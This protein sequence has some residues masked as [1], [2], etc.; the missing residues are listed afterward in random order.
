MSRYPDELDT[1]QDLPR[2][3]D[4]VT[5]VGA[6]AI[7]AVREAIFAIEAVLGVDPQG[8]QTTL[9]DRIAVSLNAN[10]TLRADAIAASGLVA[11]PIDD[12]D[13]A[14]NAGIQESKL[15]LNVGT[16]ALQ[17]Q[18]TSNDVDI[19]NLQNLLT[20]LDA[21][22]TAHTI[23]DFGRHDGYDIDLTPDLAGT[24]INTVAGA[25][26]HA[27]TEFG[28]HKAS[29]DII[30]HNAS[31]IAYAPSDESALTVDNVQDAIDAIDSGFLQNIGR[32]IDTAHSN[33]VSNDGYVVLGGQ[34]VVN[35]ASLRATR[36]VPTGGIEIAKLGLVNA[37]TI[38]SRGFSA[39]SISS[40]AQ[41]FDIKIY[42]GGAVETVSVTGLNLAAYPLAG[43]VSLRGV[44]TAINTALTATQA[45][46]T[47]FEDGNE[48]VLQH[49]IADADCYLSVEA[50]GSNS[51]I[52]ALGFASVVGVQV[53]RVPSFV[54]NVDTITRTE[55]EEV[56]V[57][58]LTLAL[59]STTL[60]LGVDVGSGG[61]NLQ[62]GQLI[63]LRDHTAAGDGTYKIQSVAASPGTTI[64]VN[65]AVPA[66]S[67]SYVIYGDTF[68]FESGRRT[69]DACVDSA[70][71]PVL[72]TRARVTVSQIGGMV[73]SEVSE[74]FPAV[75]GV[76]SVTKSSAT[77]SVKCTVGGVDGLTAT[78]EQGFIGYIKLWHPNNVDFLIYY[79]RDSSPSAPVTDTIVFSERSGRDDL[80]LVGSVFANGGVVEYPTD[81]RNVGL[82]GKLALG[83]EVTEG[84]LGRDIG[85]LHST[86]IIRGFGVSI[87]SPTTT[88]VIEGGQAYLNGLYVSLPRTSIVATNVATAG[89]WNVV[90]IDGT[91][92]ILPDLGGFE[93]SEL[94]VR[95]EYCLLAQL[96]ST[97][98]A[99]TSVTDLRFFI[100]QVDSRLGFTVDDSDLGRG[101]VRTIQAAVAR[102][103][104]LEVAPEITVLTE[105][106]VA[107][108]F[109]IDGG[110][111]IEAL[112]SLLFSS[113]LVIDGASLIVRG[114]LSVGG[115]L[116]LTDGAS[117][118]VYGLCDATE[119]S[120]GDDT[121]LNIGETFS[122]DS[123]TVTGDNVQ[124]NGLLSERSVMKFADAASPAITATDVENFKVSHI[125]LQRSYATLPVIRLSGT[126]SNIR[127][128]DTEFSQT[129]ILTEAEA[130]APARSAVHIPSG[131]DT[132]GLIWTNCEAGNIGYLVHSEGSLAN[133]KIDRQSCNLFGGIIYAT[134]DL[135]DFSV[136]DGYYAGP[137]GILINLPLSATKKGIGFYRNY[138]SDTYSGVQGNAAIFNSENDGVDSFVVQNNV[139]ADLDTANRLF[140][141][142][143]GSLKGNIS[144]NIFDT[145]VAEVY[146]NHT[147]G[148]STVD[149][150]VIDNSIYEGTGCFFRGGRAIVNGNSVSMTGSSAEPLI[151]CVMSGSFVSGAG[152]LQLSGNTIVGQS[153]QAVELLN[154]VATGNYIEAGSFTIDSTNSTSNREF[155]IEHNHFRATNTGAASAVSISTLNQGSGINKVL[156]RFQNNV[157][158]GTP[159]NTLVEIS[160]SAS[161]GL[162]MFSGN[163]LDFQ[164]PSS[165]VAVLFV[166]SSGS[167]STAS[168]YLIDDNVITANNGT[169]QYGI[170]CNF[171]STRIRK[172]TFVG[173][174]FSLAAIQ[175]QSGV[176]HAEAT[177]NIC[178][179]TG[180]SATIRHAST[181]PTAVLIERNRG[182]EDRLVFSAIGAYQEGTWLADNT[183]GYILE[184]STSTG[185]LH[186]PLSNIPVGARIV[187]VEVS[188]L[189]SSGVGSVTCTLHT[190]LDATAA[191]TNNISVTAANTISGAKQIVTLNPGSTFYVR[192]DQ[193][194]SVRVEC[195]TA[196][197]KIGSVVARVVY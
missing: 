185:V 78:F 155:S 81:L 33:G 38:R 110:T 143:T 59:S 111:K 163:L 162:L 79:V 21:E 36:Y 183:T 150:L 54:F 134:D 122:L 171:T 72:I 191:F 100:N 13:V 6:E 108:S 55:L 151:E 5:E 154:A 1:D 48:I 28:N 41:N 125:H 184:N 157:V 46:A 161:S 133:A 129:Q 188:L 60:N 76:V 98:T 196:N 67:C 160:N 140:S 15:D 187:S 178:T 137:A 132:T 170:L 69:Y 31:A 153:T 9:A 4:N 197:N 64:S 177:E 128:D 169:V 14:S 26:H 113:D 85:N 167:S 117:L 52:T 173:T 32:H 35:G 11:L 179:G 88:I 34:A 68:Q 130:A 90:L 94:I 127:L 53:G 106:T 39:T 172:N 152:F 2:V 105:T 166:G 116:T 50:A 65:V 138:V 63:H 193:V 165:G 30:Q 8:A 107:T 20:A 189:A 145:C 123:G 103:T 66:G 109:T 25:I 84:I 139:F 190:Q 37:A 89:T 186:I 95:P 73:L 61:L 99:I 24:S 142:T 144:A 149:L 62:S 57:G 51:A 27:W 102:A 91:I 180:A 114:S 12:S 195:T 77:Y 176:T 82:S 131:S 97:G 40:S 92:E 118:T 124:I 43:R 96:I 101:N 159:T 194:L 17:N 181:T 192:R 104:A 18:I 148:D 182:S 56:S 164:G 158:E 80:L 3:I 136:S 121:V 93:L 119:I 19:T 86:G 49:N 42:T 10:G 141:G 58:D 74:G 120:L 7:N 115:D 156:C 112:G 44:V 175:F 29:T 22:F 23:G 174:V 87:G 135:N 75:T 168:Q 126:C 16:Q 83:T 45:L 147:G 71:L 47:A 146:I 70:G